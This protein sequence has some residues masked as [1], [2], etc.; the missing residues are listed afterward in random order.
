VIIEV[1]PS[2]ISG[3]AAVPPNKSYTHRAIAVSALIDETSLVRRPLLSRDTRATINAV[4]RLG[5]AVRPT[6]EGLA[7]TG[8]AKLKTPDDVINV[9]NSGTTLRF[10][11]AI[12]GLPSNGFAVLTGDDSVRRRPVGPL[13]DALRPLGVEA[14]S[15][16]GD[17][18]APVIVRCGGIEGGETTVLGSQSSQYVSALLIASLR[19]QAA[20]AVN[21]SGDV[22][23]RP[24]IDATLQTI[25]MFGGEV[26]REGYRRFIVN[27]AKNLGA[28]V[29]DVPGDFGSASFLVAAT[30][31][32]H[33]KLRLK[34]LDTSL[35]QAD[36]AI[37]S[38]AEEMG[39]RVEAYE[40]E[41][42]FSWQGEGRPLR[43]SLGD[44]PDLLPPLAVMAAATPGRSVIR[45][46]AHARL[47]ESDRIHILS[48]ELAKLGISVRQLPDGLEIEGSTRLEGGVTLDS[49]GDHRVFMAFV[50]LGLGCSKGLRVSGA[51]S[52]DVSYPGF[53][54]DL[55]L[56][57]G[58]IRNEA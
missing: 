22:V 42:A 14:W 38:L 34:R 43:V 5:A 44:S 31:T 17:G 1:K 25:S 40:G 51:E 21:L 6:S 8:P 16:R 27:P 45:G 12:C 3:E 10:F 35:P 55:K 52:V 13:L 4:E 29:F 53:V 32:S 37:L 15:S 19:A 20:V 26:S 9:E 11:T 39:L 7:V 46:V 30:Y 36:A 50:A 41:A 18:C 47:K 2:K 28:T 57:G 56:L 58:R 24:Y 48:T 33:G 23:S 49:H 54:E